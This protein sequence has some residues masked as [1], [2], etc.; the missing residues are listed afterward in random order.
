MSDEFLS[1]KTLLS[2]DLDTF[3]WPTSRPGVMSAWWGH[4]PFAHWLVGAAEPR[5]I[6]ELGTHNGASFA[7][8]CEAVHRRNVAAK[9]FAVDTWQGDEHAGHYGE[10]IYQDLARFV[11]ARYAGFAELV[12]STFDDALSYFEPGSIDLLHIDGL[13]TYEAVKRDFENWFPK[14]SD[15]AVVLFHDTNV[16]ERDF[17]VWQ[18]WAELRSRYPGMEFSHA[19]GLGVLLVGAHPPGP[20]VEFCRLAAADPAALHRMHERFSQLGLAFV[21]TDMARRYMDHARQLE[22]A[23]VHLN[24]VTAERDK[25]LADLNRILS[26]KNEAVAERDRSLGNLV[27]K[28]E[29]QNEA[30]AQLSRVVAE[31]GEA[32]EQREGSL[33][34]LHLQLAHVTQQLNAAETRQLAADSALGVQLDAALAAN[35]AMRRSTSWRV[36]RPLRALKLRSLATRLRRHLAQSHDPAAVAPEPQGAPATDLGIIEQRDFAL[37]PTAQATDADDAALVER[38]GLF[39]PAFY[40]GSE[41]AY[42]LGQSPIQH[43]LASG[44]PAG[45]APS[46][47]FN[48]VFYRR[49]HDDLANVPPG[50][51]LLHYLKHG[52][53]EG[54]LGRSKVEGLSL[55]RA[56]FDP[57]KPCMVLAAHEATRTGAAI[58]SWNLAAEFSARYNVVVLLR[59][60]GPLAQSFQEVA[61]A[62]V[63]M[64]DDASLHFM[65]LEILAERMLEAYQPVFLIANSVESRCFVPAFERR[66]VPCAVLV[67]E[68]SA[69][70]RPLGVLN[71]MFEQA[72]LLVFSAQI[73]ADAAL[74]DYA[75]LAARAYHVLPQGAS[76]LPLGKDAPV[77]DI[78]TDGVPARLAPMT[79]DL[80]SVDPDAFL[81]VGL[82][83]I[84]AR[85]GVEFFIAAADRARR[86]MPA[87]K[88][89]FAW[90]GKC[91]D[92]DAPYL[93]SLLE[94]VERAGLQGAFAFWGELADLDP[95]YQRADACFLCSRLDPLPNVAI[96][97]SLAGVPVVAFAQASG[98]SD[99]LAESPDTARLVVPYL[100]AAAAAD[101]VCAMA[102]D[103]LL[104]DQLGTS[105]QRMARQHFDMRGY[106]MRLEQLALAEVDAVTRMDADQAFL[107]LP[108]NFNAP[109]YAGK[110]LDSRSV[111]G[112]VAHYLRSSRLV[113]PRG[114]A[115]TGRLLR[116]PLE[117]FHPLIYA[118][119]AP[120]F[121]EARDP[122]P[123]V[124]FLQAGKPE[125]RWKHA[126][127]RPMTGLPPRTGLSVALHAHFHYPELFPDFARRLKCNATPVA[128]YLTAT[129]EA[130]AAELRRMVAAEGLPDAHVL[131]VENCGRD[132]GPM[133]IQLP[134]EVFDAHEVVG[135]FHSKRSPHVDE[136]IGGAWRDF[137]LEHLLGDA[138][139]MLDTILNAFAD[140]ER[141]GLVFPEDPHLNDWDAN[142]THAEA[143]AVRMALDPLPRHLD[144]P[145]GTMFW[146]RAAALR[147]LLDIRL[148][149]EDFPKEPLPIDGTMLHALERLLPFVAAKAGYAYATTHVDGHRR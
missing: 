2:D 143:L 27:Q 103:A 118:G 139:P 99:V 45:L 74:R 69:S 66:R 124:H 51:L 135:H 67:H 17:G 114:R 68:F 50:G 56:A 144:F 105:V 32:V 71:E 25:T 53:A 62:C 33:R 3:F 79:S 147:P 26:E 82:G 61:A 73:V 55:P 148:S 133:L 80:G 88:V 81:V 31:Q 126:V 30:M 129:G 125:G 104:R 98:F 141:L 137:I 130:Q 96:D 107:M 20:L 21:Q 38:S 140:D 5:V 90:I 86:R 12:R 34:L 110:A 142:R 29:A 37:A 72:S 128:L 95:V 89:V 52:Q 75:S 116:R 94:Q 47:D 41:D 19:H 115:R 111:E 15:R 106:V 43:Y 122:D 76:K 10:E 9:C 58:L 59:R 22:V 145:Q 70:I 54:R 4:V 63:V 6:V 120:G 11:D 14:L 18:L 77:T 97:A 78:V 84:T 136:T 8:F 121:D 117:G 49:L 101:V 60:G 92:F 102:E 42:R 48:P 112:H 108:G 13:H 83:T 1:V 65:E 16:R 138:S 35:D 119:E 149:A 109:L 36:T 113:A 127:I 39:D 132:I 23:N 123:L 64:P 28:L 100:D 93:Q 46:R 44:E 131:L 85:K 146:A 24:G 57:S 91:Y 87:R 134:A 40:A 7:A